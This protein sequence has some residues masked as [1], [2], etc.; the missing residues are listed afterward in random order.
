MRHA[1][2]R[3]LL[4]YMRPYRGML[5]LGTLYAAIGASAQ[6]YSPVLIG[7]VINELGNGIRPQV[8]A[9]YAFGI[10]GLS[11]TLAL[12]RY[13]LRMLTGTIAVGVSYQMSKDMFDRLLTFDR[14][15]LMQYGIGD[16][17]SR[18]SS[19]FIYIWRF[20]SAGF[21]MS[22]HAL[23]LIGIG[24][25]LMARSSPLLA[26]I[27]IVMLTVSVAAQVGLGR[28]MER[29]FDRVQHELGR[30]SAF[31]QEHLSA[32][33]TLMAYAQEPAAAA[34]FKNL[35]ES[36]MQR[37]LAFVLRSSAISPLPTLMVRLSSTVVLGLG[38]AMIINGTLTVGEYVQFIVYLVVLS[39]AAQSLGQAFERLQQGSAA[40][41][42][43]GE[44]LRRRPQIVD[45]PEAIKPPLQGTIR[46]EGVGVQAE[47][48]WVLRDINIEIPAGTTLGIVGATGSGKSTLLS[49]IGR[50]RDVDEGRVTIDGHDVRN[51]KLKHL[52]RSV[53]Y[54]LQET[55]LFSMALQE[56]ITL[57]LDA[58][59]DERIH[60]AA[61]MARLNNDLAQLPQGLGTIVGERG[62]TLSG[63][64]KQRTAI[65]R[66]LIRDPKILLLDDSLSS[67]DT[68]TAAEV[69]SALGSIS[70]DR[71][72]IV[73]SQRLASVR[74][75]DQII[76]LDEGRI[77][78][79]GTHQN[80]LL[81]NGLYAAMYR[82]ELQQ[83]EEGES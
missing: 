75:A 69:L 72:R 14:A 55:L 47:E 5:L 74:D 10:I 68:Q 7:Q 54:V 39:G 46:F 76:V 30:L 9:L 67:V 26:T 38:G 29:A 24:C 42:R 63:G 21:Q 43:I 37:N 45:S 4:P 31:S 27:V 19:D 6:A 64:Q 81:H 17:L 40:A 83:S 28:V 18:A 61:Q 22:M 25:A 41:G 8:L 51:I 70:A 71:T 1:G 23:F 36:Y 60:L 13:L 53:T 58:V 2:L 56:N 59:P 49:L 57:G 16:L 32:A 66:A 78:E 82:R 48:R 62:A 33:R 77:V 11:C 44:I 34:A 73:V 35:N 50:I 80:L 12:F 79:R 52:R 20:Y 3:F 15:A 65:A